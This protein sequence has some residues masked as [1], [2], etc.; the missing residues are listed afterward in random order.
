M[1]PVRS[2]YLAG[3]TAAACVV[4]CAAPIVGFL[5]AAGFAATAATFA[6]AGAVFAMVVGLITIAALVVRRSR[7]KPSTCT[8]SPTAS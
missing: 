6:F 7:A 1:S 2:R 8:V 5:G 4:C 3:G